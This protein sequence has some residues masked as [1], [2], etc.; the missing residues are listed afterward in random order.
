[1]LTEQL[2]FH[3][4][5]SCI[6]EGND[7]PL[8]CSFLKNPRDWGAWWVAVY[9]VAQSWTRL[10]WL[11]SSSSNLILTMYSIQLCEGEINICVLVTVICSF[12]SQILLIPSDKM[13][14]FTLAISC[15]TTSATAAAAKLLQSSLT[16]YNPIDSSP[17]GSPIPGILQARTLEWVPNSFSNA[18]KWK[19]KVKLLNYVW[20][21]TTPWTAAY[22]A[23]PS[24]GFSRQEYWSGLPL[25][26]PSL[27]IDEMQIKTTMRYHLTLVRIPTIKK[28]YKQ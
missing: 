18:W 16:L 7:N 8:Q 28:I 15:L 9:G 27:I 26:S 4:L 13:S 21:F 19:V 1:M 22:Q 25:P 20:L 24:I 11:S 12:L 14:I 3:F 2:H 10:K 6:G 5:F 23:P 17:P